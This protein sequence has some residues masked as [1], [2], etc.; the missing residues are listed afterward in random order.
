MSVKSASI[1]AITES[2][3]GTVSMGSAVDEVVECD[4][5]LQAEVGH[6]FLEKLAS[7]GQKN[8]APAPEAGSSDAPPA[9]RS[10]KEVVGGKKVTAKHYR[11][12]EM[13][14]AS[15]PSLKISKSA[16]GMRPESSEEAARASPPP[17]PS[18]APSG[19]GKSPAS[20]RGG[21]TS[22]GRAAPEPADLRAEEDLDAPEAPAPPKT[23]PMP[24]PASSSGEPAAAKPTPPE[25]TKLS[26]QEPAV[27]ATAASAPSSGTRSLVLHT[28]RAAIVA[29]ETASAQLGRITELT[30]GGAD[31]GHL[32][33]Y[34]E[35]WNQADLSPATRGLGKD[36]LPGMLDVRKQLFE[37]LLWEHRE[38]S[39]A[40]SKC[41][42][43]PEAS[44]KALKAQLAALQAEK[45]QLASEHHKAL[46]AQRTLVGELKE[47]LMQDELRHARELKEAKAVA[48]AKL[49]ESLK[50]YTNKTAVLQAELEEETV[51]R[52][53]AQDQI[54][55]LTAEQKEYDRLVVQ[56]DAL[57]LRLFP[58]S[59]AHAHNK[60]A[61]RRAEQEMSNP[62]SPWDA[63]D[64]LVALSAWIQHMRA[65]DRHLVDLP[66]RAME[67]FKELWPEEAVPST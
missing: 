38:L 66:D 26:A 28:G 10:R 18:P 46:E 37:E 29:G 43:V 34:A 39:E 53:A 36:K 59:Q 35:K 24:P 54:A 4:V 15:G 52:K 57:A 44:I 55:L 58:D 62:Y 5:P 17:Q 42:A 41:Q 50:E 20:S 56:T 63:Y 11:S 61:E 27:V 30:R 14:V 9:K 67:I 49:D 60:V 23:T 45:E 22:A 2:M 8:K 31:L 32:L 7:R 6:E 3:A 65:V 13:P 40:H 64:H 1:V 25:G 33:D 47:K 51:A 12:R 21:N 16:T 19:D 48:E